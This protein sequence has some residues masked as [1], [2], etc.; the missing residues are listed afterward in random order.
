MPKDTYGELLEPLD[1]EYETEDPADITEN[2]WVIHWERVTPDNLVAIV[3]WLATHV[4]NKYPN[5]KW[6]DDGATTKSDV[7]IVSSFDRLKIGWGIR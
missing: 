2:T 6:L 4:M 3:A 7:W 5:W 1:R